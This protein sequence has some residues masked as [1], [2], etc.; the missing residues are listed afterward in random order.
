MLEPAT[1]LP[2]HARQMALNML[3]VFPEPDFRPDPH[4]ASPG[5]EPLEVCSPTSSLASS[6]ADNEA[7]PALPSEIR[8]KEQR[9]ISPFLVEIL[10]LKFLSGRKRN[11]VTVN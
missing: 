4:S 11:I 8:A 10:Q 9:S 5:S 7:C 1:Q 2:E 3:T 6:S